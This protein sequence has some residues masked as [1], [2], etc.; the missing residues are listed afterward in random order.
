MTE[1]ALE[2]GDRT[3]LLVGDYSGAVE[4][5][6]CRNIRS[7][8]MVLS[9]NMNV[10]GKV[11]FSIKKVLAKFDYERLWKSLFVFRSKRF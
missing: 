11:C 1:E 5:A 2:D 10:C 9:R 4:G 6:A 3:A 7:L 8:A